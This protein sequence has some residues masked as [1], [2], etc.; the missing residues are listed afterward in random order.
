ML[1]LE[2]V[3]IKFPVGTP[4]KYYPLLSNKSNFHEGV[5]RTEPWMLCGSVVVSVS[6]KAG[7]LD[8]EHLE[9][10]LTSTEAAREE[11]AKVGI[12][13]DNITTEQMKQL[14]L[15]LSESL[16]QSGLFDGTYEMNDFTEGDL[17]L[18]CRT[19]LWDSREAVTFNCDGFIGFAGWASTTNTQP[20]LNGIQMWLWSD[21][22][23]MVMN[24]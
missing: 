2:Q 15:C 18:T 4:V 3:A 22:F 5:I 1:T 17:H 13:R 16:S 6:G 19:N 14:H 10:A 9:V 7:C 21:Q 8:I 24:G 12:T 23:A 20:I 11:I